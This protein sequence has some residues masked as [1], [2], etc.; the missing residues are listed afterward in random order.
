MRKIMTMVMVSGLTLAGVVFSAAPAAAVTANC[1]KWKIAEQGGATCTGSGGQWRLWLDCPW[2]FDYRSNWI[3]LS[4][5][6]TSVSGSCDPF[7]PRSVNIE[8]RS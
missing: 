5:T 1:S 2:G 3:T 6:P 4:S 7:A 8:T